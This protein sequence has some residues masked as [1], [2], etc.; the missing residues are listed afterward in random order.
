MAVKVL[1]NT[2]ALLLPAKLKVSLYTFLNELFVEEWLVGEGGG[3]K[4]EGGGWKGGGVVY[5][6]FGEGKSTCGVAHKIT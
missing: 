5:E 3:W 4:G 1:S 6:L 2:R